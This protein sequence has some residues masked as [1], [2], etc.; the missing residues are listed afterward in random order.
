MIVFALYF[1]L[2]NK[3]EIQIWINSTPGNSNQSQNLHVMVTTRQL[4]HI[5]DLIPSNL[6]KW[7]CTC[8]YIIGCISKGQWRIYS[9]YTHLLSV[10]KN[11][12]DVS[13]SFEVISSP[14]V[15]PI[16]WGHPVQ[17]W[18]HIR[19]H[20]ITLMIE[21]ARWRG[22]HNMPLTILF[23]IFLLGMVAA[24]GI[25]NLQFVDLNSSRNLF[26]I[27]YSFIMGLVIPNWMNGNEDFIN[28]GTVATK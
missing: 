2:T 23:F 20:N 17:G 5:T 25:S 6:G 18:Q 8:L 21:D 13:P 7:F 26:I 14:I 22:S 12:I 9:Y 1:F 11:F 19:A 15:V 28:T 10:D 16:V 24:V 27:G 4:Q 3:Q